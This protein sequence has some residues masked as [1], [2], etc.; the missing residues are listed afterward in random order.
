MWVYHIFFGDH[1]RDNGASSFPFLLELLSALWGGGINT[2]EELMVLIGVSEGI[3]GLFWFIQMTS[4]SVPEWFG[5]FV[6]EES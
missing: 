1:F 3:E 5:D 6:V 2:K 4:V